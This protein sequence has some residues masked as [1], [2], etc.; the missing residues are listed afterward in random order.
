MSLRI[1]F[2]FSM[3][4]DQLLQGCFIRISF[5]FHQVLQGFWSGSPGILIIF[6]QGFDQFI[7][8]LIRFC[9]VFTHLLHGVWIC[10]PTVF[11][12]P[13]LRCFNQLLRGFLISFS[14]G[15]ES[16]YSRFFN[17]FPHGLWICF[18]IV[19][20]S[21]SSRFLTSFSTVGESASPRFLNHLLCGFRII[22]S[23]A[24]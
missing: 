18:C 3:V 15:F 6:Y 1:L 19:C 9:T 17:P 8:F 13:S 5:F 24:F 23:T 20:D 22:L 10:F 14:A 2:S 21:A 4:F 12:S 11:Q 7:Q 16:T